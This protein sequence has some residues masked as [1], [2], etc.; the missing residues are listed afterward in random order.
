MEASSPSSP[1]SPPERLS[2]AEA[3]ETFDAM[4]SGEVTPSQ[5]AAS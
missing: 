5:M 4:L 3:A 2:R 1:K